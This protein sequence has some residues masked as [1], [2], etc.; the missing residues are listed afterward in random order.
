MKLEWYDQ[1]REQGHQVTIQDLV[2]HFSSIPKAKCKSKNTARAWV[3]NHPEL[4]RINGLIL[5]ADEAPEETG[6]KR[7]KNEID[8]SDS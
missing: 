7:V 4:V 8:P 3:D 6:V 2:D 1:Q 5:Y